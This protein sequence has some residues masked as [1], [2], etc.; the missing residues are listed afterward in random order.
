MNAK[1]RRSIREEY[2]EQTRERILQAFVDCLEDLQDQPV[3]DV[4][5]SAIAERAGVAERTVYRHFPKRVDLLA[6]AGEWI[7]ENVFSYIHPASLEE[8]PQVFREVCRRFDRHPNLAYAIALSRIGRSMRVGFRHWILVENRKS[9]EQFTSHLPPEEVRRAE[10]VIAYLDNVLAWVTM[11]EELGLSGEKV[12][13]A[14]EWAL[15]TLLEGLRC[16][17]EAAAKR[18]PSRKLD[19]H[20]DDQNSG[21]RKSLE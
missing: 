7:N 11:R 2:A 12:A 19:G 21:E 20:T 1:R 17:D 3:D 10:A 16:R 8:L 4:P 15:M 13:D 14:I 18:T 9:L 6:A 5:V